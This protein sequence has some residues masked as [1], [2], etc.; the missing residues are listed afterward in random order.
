MVER[1]ICRAAAGVADVPPTAPRPI[2]M[3]LGGRSVVG[4][5]DEDDKDEYH[6]PYL[7]RQMSWVHPRTPGDSPPRFYGKWR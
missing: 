2:G 1:V 6:D 5:D 3:A 4:E 7:V